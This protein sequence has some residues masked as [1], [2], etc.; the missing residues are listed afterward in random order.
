MERRTVTLIPGDGI[1]PEIT[2]AVQDIFEAARAPIDW[3]VAEAGMGSV[4]ASGSGLP[5][6]T[7]E[8]MRRNQVALK[9][10]TTTPVGVGHKSVNV[11]IRKSLDLFANVRPALSLPAIKTRYE[12]IDLMVV[13]ENIEDTYGGIEHWQTPDAAQCLRVITRTGSRAVIRYALEMARSMGRDRV[14]CVHKASIHKMT[15]GLF[16]DTFRELSFGYPSLECND[17]V[18]D[19]LC[20]QLVSRPEQFDVLVLPNLFGDIVSDLCA[21]LVGGLGVAPA[22]NIGVG[23]AVFE[24]VHGSAPDIAGLGLANP[25]AILLSAIQ[26][27]RYLDLHDHANDIDTALR[28]ALLSGIKTRD[29]GGH[30]TTIEFTRVVINALPRKERYPKS[31]Q[32]HQSRTP[33]I[34][35]AAQP[36]PPQEHP[37]APVWTLCGVDVFVRHDEGIPQ[38]PAKSGI[39]KLHMISNRGTKVAPGPAPDITLVNWH[40]CRYLAASLLSDDAIFRLLQELTAQGFRWMHVEKLHTSEDGPLYSLA[41]GE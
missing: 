38:V 30:A 41:Q 21:G 17:I 28:L 22:A 15:D 11:A 8:S 26:M 10:P 34:S 3:D 40:C 16:L 18:I 13:R 14:T 2:E 36:Q 5:A 19:N 7:L 31:L 35:K 25:T 4:K 12:N 24:A 33:R 27:L 29:L 37:A 20:M 23:R 6:E 32:S 39:L 1:G 9:G